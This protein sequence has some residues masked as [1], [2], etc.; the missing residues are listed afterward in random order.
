MLPHSRFLY[1]ALPPC[2][3]A[4]LVRCRVLETI[5][6]VTPQIYLAAAETVSVSIP[7]PSYCRVQGAK[8]FAADYILKWENL[9]RSSEC[10]NVLGGL[11]SRDCRPAPLLVLTVNLFALLVSVPPAAWPERKYGVVSMVYYT[12]KSLQLFFDSTSVLFQDPGDLF[13]FCLVSVCSF[14]LFLSSIPFLL[15][16]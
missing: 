15:R 12:Q 10:R 7:P 4:R 6:G 1:Q 16:H 9:R 5:P 13:S 8:H 2:K 14:V 3:R 11:I